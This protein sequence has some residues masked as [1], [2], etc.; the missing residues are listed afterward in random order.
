MAGSALYAIILV[1]YILGISFADASNWTF[2]ST[3]AAAYAAIC[4]NIHFIYTSNNLEFYITVYRIFY[5]L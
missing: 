5:Y 2:V 4:N 3:Y 1:D